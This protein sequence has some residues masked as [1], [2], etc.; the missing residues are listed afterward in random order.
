MQSRSATRELARLLLISAREPGDAARVVGRRPVIVRAGARPG[1]A[2]SLAFVSIS[3]RSACA[4][5]PTPTSFLNDAFFDG[6]SRSM[7]DVDAAET[8][9]PACYTDA[10]FLRLR[11]GGAVQSRMAVRGPRRLGE[12]AR[13]LFH[14]HDHR[15]AD[16]RHAATGSG[17][18]K[19][20]SAVCQHRAMLVAEARAT[21]AA[22]SAPIIT[23]SI[24]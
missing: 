9:P 15:R 23:G 10:A 21:P 22:L 17:E 20:M 1:D 5:G 13:R 2:P 6:L 8:P 4:M 18:I 7:R 16:H 24:R 19:A 14:H 12:G 3:R 11:E